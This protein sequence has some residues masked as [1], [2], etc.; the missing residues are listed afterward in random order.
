[1]GEDGADGVDQ[2]H[3]EEEDDG[4]DDLEADLMAAFEEDEKEAASWDTGGS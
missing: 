4:E 2:I 3:P 1:V